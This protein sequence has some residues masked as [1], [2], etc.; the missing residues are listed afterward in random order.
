M[1]LPLPALLPFVL[2]QVRAALGPGQPVSAWADASRL[3]VGGCDFL[4]RPWQAGADLPTPG[5][6]AGGSPGSIVVAPYI[7]AAAARQLRQQGQFYADAM[8]NLWLEVL[9][10]GLSL[11]VTGRRSRPWPA[12]SGMAFQLQELRLLF[13]LLTTPDLLACSD[14]ELAQRTRVPR[15]VGAEVLA[16]LAQHGFLLL[17][18]GRRLAHPAVLTA[19]WIAGYGSLLR[20]RLPTQRYRL[21]AGAPGPLPWGWVAHRT[22]SLLGGTAAA[23]QLPGNDTVPAAVTLYNRR[24]HDVSLLRAAG[25]EPHPT[26][27]VEVVHLF[28]SPETSPDRCCV[29]PLLVYADLVL[30]GDHESRAAAEQIRT[31]Y[32]PHLTP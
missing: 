6:A 7:P 29:H 31:H 26:G 14:A 13:Y 20:A 1:T 16:N 10:R 2:H 23:G 24:P 11:L 8:G 28:A 22:H 19:R 21:A 5:L 18:N 15:S 12:A 9:P 17:E 4:L 27:P 3:T 32:L 30:A 25:L